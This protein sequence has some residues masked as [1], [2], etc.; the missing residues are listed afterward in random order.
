MGIHR[1][2]MRHVVKGIAA[3]VLCC[4]AAAYAGEKTVWLVRPLYPGQEAL[5]TK[6]EQSLVSI[7]PDAQRGD[8]IIGIKELAR[9]LGP[10]RYEQIPCLSG[11]ERCADPTDPFVAK[12]GVDRIVMVMGGQDESG[13]NFKVTSYRP[14]K[15]ESMGASA[16]NAVMDRA[17]LGAIVKVVPL[18]STLE[19][20]SI[21]SGAVVYVDD[22]KVGT[23]PLSTQVLPG[24]RV[25]RVDLKQHE[26][27]EKALLIQARAI[28]KFDFKLDKVAARLSVI[29]KPA[30]T[31]ISIDGQAVGKDRVDR[32]IAP[33]KHTI[34]LS[35]EGYKDSEE[36][37]EVKPE[38]EYNLDKTLEAIPGADK[39][40]NIVVVERKP[41]VVVG[42]VQ[43]PPEEK[44][45][46]EEKPL[47]W[48]EQLYKR[49]N[50]F[51]LGFDYVNLLPRAYETS[52]GQRIR[53][54]L[55][56]RRWGNEGI[57]RAAFIVQDDAS[58]GLPMMGASG[59]FGIMGKYFGIT[60][61]GV[62]AHFATTPVR[63][64]VGT[65]GSMLN[66]D[67]PNEVPPTD[68]R[69]TEVKSPGDFNT[70]QRCP[71][72]TIANCSY[73]DEIDVNLQ[74]YTLRAI[75]PQVRL[76]VWRFQ[77]TLAAGLEFRAGYV[78]EKAPTV[79]TYYKDGFAV[80][81]LMLGVRFQTRVYLVD[82]FFLQGTFQ[83]LAYLWGES[84]VVYNPS[85][86]LGDT[87]RGPSAIGFNAG[88]GY[89]F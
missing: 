61:V 29:A 60:V 2:A 64:R 45:P 56:A 46:E 73:P 62:S 68:F 82:G 65:D 27:V 10:G 83:Y 79:D 20:T 80:L 21:P 44:K 81:D 51:Y 38:Q 49:G 52:D 88:L 50:Y 66:P 43:P 12:L 36:Q 25:L 57:G 86:Q 78:L 42:A 3:L 58:K 4:S 32:G 72:P 70:R 40:T 19:V 87:F 74:M 35:A 18:A 26:P 54:G 85:T 16:S 5:V 47:T 77:F 23:T 71:T 84:G 8:E 17:F 33:G 22:Q 37:I 30:G 89:A 39:P 75:H 15:G 24:N 28:G 7:I 67:A 41:D 6:I 55:A 9:L 1:G 53:T 76:A 63:V 11:E 48:T 31:T 59:E 13:Y 14:A 34:R 69:P